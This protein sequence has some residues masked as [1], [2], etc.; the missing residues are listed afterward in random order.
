MSNP[1]PSLFPARLLTIALL[2]TTATTASGQKK[3]PGA[4]QALVR[5]NT[6][7][8][9]ALQKG[10]SVTLRPMLGED[11]VF[12]DPSGTAQSKSQL[13]SSVSRGYRLQI[14]APQDVTAHVDGSVGFITFKT[15]GG[16]SGNAVYVMRAGRWQLASQRISAGANATAVVPVP[17]PLV[18][19]PMTPVMPTPLPINDNPGRVMTARATGTFD[20]V[21]KPIT[22]YNTSAP[23]VIG[24][25]S[26]DK[27]FHGELEAVSKGEMLTGG[28]FTSGS[29]GYV[30]MERVVGKLNGRKGSFIL[31]HTGTMDHGVSGL[32]V[33]V[34]PGSGT[35]ELAGLTGSMTIVIDKTK[36]SYEFSYQ[37]PGR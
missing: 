32:T 20:V 17:A 37:L 29:A 12:T 16:A 25:M 18:R 6:A 7:L 4:D 28:A 30:A 2:V 11:L 35:D 13:L 3:D 8:L 9:D 19:K 5:V 36:H 27:Q 34:V 22:P 33:T 23:S 24:R 15:D 10:D 26:I 21:V 31:Q 14:G 1:L